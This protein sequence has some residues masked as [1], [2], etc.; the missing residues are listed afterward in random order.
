M[1]TAGVAASRVESAAMGQVAWQFLD[2]D[3]G[4]VLS[5]EGMYQA[6]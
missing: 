3:G 4:V 1:Q 2:A 6:P 5:G